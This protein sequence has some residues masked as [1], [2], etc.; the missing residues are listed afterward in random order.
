MDS[1]SL[2][3]TQNRSHPFSR[4]SVS[5]V[6]TSLLL[7]YISS[8][9]TLRFATRQYRQN[10]QLTTISLLA[11]LP[12]TIQQRLESTTGSAVL[13]STRYRPIRSQLFQHITL[14]SQ[15]GQPTFSAY[16]LCRGLE[17][18]AAPLDPTKADVV[19][20]KL[21][22][23][24]YIFG[25]PATFFPG[26][27]FMAEVLKARGLNVCILSL[28]Y[29]WAPYATF[30]TQIEQA[31]R[32]YEYLVRGLGVNPERI[33]VFGE[34][35]GGHLVLALLVRLRSM[36]RTDKPAVAMLMSPWVDLLSQNPHASDTSDFLSRAT[37][38]RAAKMLLRDTPRRTFQLYT[39]FA[40]RVAARGESWKDILASKTWMSAGED[41]FFLRDIV[42]FYEQA[43]KDG[44][45]VVLEVEKGGAH[46]WQGVE[47]VTSGGQKKFLQSRPGSS[48][49][50]LNPGLTRIASWLADVIDARKQY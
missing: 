7:Q 28:E 2:H 19:I 46:V 22:G 20:Y 40:E 16:W 9:H 21:H 30:P 10:T 37:L 6:R 13:T 49:E 38:D 27:M 12:Y 1:S 15:P 31:V 4:P 25:Q 44:A 11:R 5:R 26:F 14:P 39:N 23:G 47:S 36:G 43:K 35:A 17:P 48:V 33:C 18:S 34:S 3:P 45:D 24:A 50:G 29:T 8:Q 41:E 32:G 42:N